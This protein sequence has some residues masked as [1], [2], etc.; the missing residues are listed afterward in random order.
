MATSSAS[1]EASAPDSSSSSSSPDPSPDT[2]VIPELVLDKKAR[3]KALAGSNPQAGSEA[4]LVNKVKDDESLAALALALRTSTPG[5]FHA[6]SADLRSVEAS[7]NGA[8]ALKDA[9]EAAGL[10][11]KV[12]TP[13]E[14]ITY[15]SE[16]DATPSATSTRSTKST[17]S[18][19]ASS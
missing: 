2:T 18:T 9:L 10:K 16:P 7:I 13:D 8:I 11:I 19:S 15:Q 5:A 4:A 6:L 14:Y 17:S 3:V 1:S 12:M